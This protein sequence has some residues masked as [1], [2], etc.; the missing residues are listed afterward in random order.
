MALTNAYLV[1]TKNLSGF[2]SAL[3]SAKAPERLTNKFLKQL[4]FTSSNDSLF[5]GL[6]KALGFLDEA[7]VPTS[8]YFNYLD[9]GQAGAVL[10]EG[11]RDAYEDLFALNKKAQNMTR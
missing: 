3:Q 6:L 9:Q 11:I 10:A 4:D 7:G 8:R 5:I 1:T 2:L